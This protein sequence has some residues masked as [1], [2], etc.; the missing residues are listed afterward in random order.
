MAEPGAEVEPHTRYNRWVPRFGAMMRVSC[1]HT[2]I[3]RLTRGVVGARADKLDIMLLTTTGRR[4]G[5]Q[6]TNPMPYFRDGDAY[7]IVG[8]FGGS[9]RHPGWFHNI[10]ACGEARLQVRGD[11]FAVDA[12]AVEAEERTRLWDMVI[13][14]QPR[15]V[16]YQSRTERRIPIVVFRRKSGDSPN[17]SPLSRA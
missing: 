5:T 9:D 16:D 3:Y 12:A 17:C 4:T 7:V 2:W 13:A 11:R 6:R 15:Y 14:R 1:I 8:S 10:Q